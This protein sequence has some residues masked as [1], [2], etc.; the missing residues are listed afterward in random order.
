MNIPRPLLPLICLTL[1]M[2]GCASGPNFAE[3]SS[4]LHS[5][6]KGQGR[7]W[8]YRPNKV[9]S[10]GVQPD[11]LLNGE[12]IGKAQPG[13]YFFV[14]RKPGIYEAKCSTE[15]TNRTKFTLSS[16]EDKFIRLWVLPGVFVGHIIPKE[17]SRDN[18]LREIAHCKLVTADRE[19]AGSDGK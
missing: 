8:F 2:V 6:A 14:D 17:T 7:V 4:K 12:K 15:W 1:S 19:N 13:G 5:P 9:V 18:G 16:H 3:Y 11:V 10:L